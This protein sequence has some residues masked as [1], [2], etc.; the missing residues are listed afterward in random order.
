M[1]P[2]RSLT[3]ISA[4]SLPPTVLPASGLTPPAIAHRALRAMLPETG[5]FF[6]FSFFFKFQLVL[7]ILYIGQTYI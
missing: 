6:L 4:I 5:W 3:P 2:E 7:C 1:T